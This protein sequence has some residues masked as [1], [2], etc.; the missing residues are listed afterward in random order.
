M[1][2]PEIDPHK[3][4]ATIS[5]VDRRGEAEEAASFAVTPD[6][7][8]ELLGFLSDSELV[9]D[10]IGVEGSSSLGQPLALALAAAG[11]DVR[12]VQPNRTAER[13]RRRRRAKTARVRSGRP[14]TV[15]VTLA[16]TSPGRR[17]QA[18]SQT[19]DS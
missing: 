19:P 14:R 1:A 4:S 18:S 16:T 17:Q 5:L 12:E 10:R 13:R 3:H 8:A 7:I 11:Y 6:G 2:L 15:V 9:I